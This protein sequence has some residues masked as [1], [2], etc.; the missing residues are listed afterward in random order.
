[1]IGLCQILIG[2]TLLWNHSD[3]K[4]IAENTLWGPAALILFLG[5]FAQFLCWLGWSSTSKKNRCYLAL[6]NVLIVGLVIAQSYGCFW[7]FKLRYSLVP[8]SI[9]FEAGIDNSFENFLDQHFKYEF[10]HSWNRIQEQYQCCGVDGPTDYR[11]GASAL[12]WSCCGKSEDPFVTDCSQIYQRGCLGVLT[13]T[14][15]KLLLYAAVTAF[16][17]ATFQS[18]GLFCT[19]QLVL[20]LRRN[21]TEEEVDTSSM[22]FRQKLNRELKP[23]TRTQIHRKL[24]I[25]ESKPDTIQNI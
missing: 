2:G 12:P 1:L 13:H 18:A 7:A 21:E 4:S 22:S 23:L 8:R 17:A 20:S 6:F 3:F 25:E 11:R 15:K 16:V 9:S 24:K 19:I 10:S 5:I 14:I